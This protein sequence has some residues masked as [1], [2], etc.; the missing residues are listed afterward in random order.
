[1]DISL[2]PRAALLCSGEHSSGAQTSPAELGTLG[3]FPLLSLGSSQEEFGWALVKSAGLLAFHSEAQFSTADSH[4][5]VCPN[6]HL[7][8][9]LYPGSASVSFSP[10]AS[11][12]S[13]KVNTVHVFRQR[14][15]SAALH[16]FLR[17]YPVQGNLYKDY[18][19]NWEARVMLPHME[20]RKFSPHFL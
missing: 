19:L 7:K 3:P 18:V 15:E 13:K 2:L 12:S 14:A 11:T 10:F 9:I 6:Y 5:M 1:M 20:M 16:P 17:M 8:V 4:E